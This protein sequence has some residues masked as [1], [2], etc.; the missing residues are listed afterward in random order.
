[1]MTEIFQNWCKFFDGGG[2]VESLV[3]LLPS[4]SR[5]HFLK[6]PL[7]AFELD[8]QWV[9]YYYMQIATF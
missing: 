4:P 6:R 9:C 7:D 2:W 8:M 3:Q 1:M 5:V